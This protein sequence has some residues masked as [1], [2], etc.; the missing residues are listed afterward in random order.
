MKRII[1]LK[2]VS[3]TGK[4]TKINQIAD[5]II[6]KYSIPNTI[7]L[8]IIDF[9]KDTM[10]LLKV[11]NLIIGINTAGDD[12]ECIKQIDTIAPNCDILI[13]SC[14]TKGV[15][16]QHIYKNYNH[17]SGWLETKIIVD[18]IDPPSVVHQS[19]RD[20]NIIDEIQTWLIGMEK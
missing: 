4:T 6:R 19:I 1:I 3:N 10:G 2:G 11:N 18:K 17:N 15:T 20:A 5:W 9:E 16:Y 8:D 13:C 12:D 14:R 7:G